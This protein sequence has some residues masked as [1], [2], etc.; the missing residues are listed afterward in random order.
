MTIGLCSPALLLLKV[1]DDTPRRIGPA[2]TL[3]LAM[4]AVI[5][6]EFRLK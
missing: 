4:I 3:S 6:R 5:N 2:I 1:D